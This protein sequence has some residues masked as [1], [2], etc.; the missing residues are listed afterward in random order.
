VLIPEFASGSLTLKGSDLAPEYPRSLPQ[1][2]AA[3][4]R[5][6]TWH[7]TLGSAFLMGTNEKSSQPFLLGNAYEIQKTMVFITRR[8]RRLIRP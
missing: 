2:C 5:N 6:P 8:L 7:K 3:D 4:L 1:M